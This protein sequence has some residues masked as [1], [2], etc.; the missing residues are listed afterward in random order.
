MLAPKPSL[1][2]F[3]IDETCVG[4][5]VKIVLPLDLK[6]TPCPVTKQ[7]VDSFTDSEREKAGKAEMAESLDDLKDKV[8]FL[9]QIVIKLLIAHPAS[10]ALP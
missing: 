3:N 8:R 9:Q 6:A 4:E 2:K 7:N 10:R 1:F 5:E